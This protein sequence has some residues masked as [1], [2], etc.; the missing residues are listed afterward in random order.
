MEYMS[1][2]VYLGG[3]YPETNRTLALQDFQMAKHIE[4]ESHRI[5]LHHD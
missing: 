1:R 4:Q 3:D 5:K 2:D